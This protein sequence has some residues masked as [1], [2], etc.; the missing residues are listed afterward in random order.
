[1]TQTGSKQSSP[2]SMIDDWFTHP[3]NTV[4]PMATLCHLKYQCNYV[5]FEPNS[6]FKLSGVN[7]I[8]TETKAVQNLS[9]KTIFCSAYQ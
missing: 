5:S 2:V 1:M 6:W 8:A 3:A 4:I 9:D 7:F